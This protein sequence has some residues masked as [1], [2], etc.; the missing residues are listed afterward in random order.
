MVPVPFRTFIA[1]AKQNQK[2]LI[3][4]FLFMVLLDFFAGSAFK[5]SSSST[6]SDTMGQA[7]VGVA[8]TYI[9]WGVALLSIVFL[10]QAELRRNGIKLS[11]FSVG[12]AFVKSMSVWLI[13]VLILSYVVSIIAKQFSGFESKEA[14]VVL[15]ITL[16]ILTYLSL[17]YAVGAYQL[18]LGNRIWVSLAGKKS[19]NSTA[20]YLVPLKSF[21][22]FVRSPTV[23]FALIVIVGIKILQGVVGEPLVL[24]LLS[25]VPYL[26]FVVIM[27]AS[28]GAVALGVT[29]EN[30][31][32]LFAENEL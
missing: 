22:V 19:G 32:Q 2:Y 14:T 9:S 16:S 4:L 27:A 1:A 31:L 10:G 29:E 13:F 15:L 26:L 17:P 7:L 28:S 30:E 18:I 20:W 3:W 5:L 25:P 6:M 12:Y 23:F 11:R 21:A 8:T 24:A